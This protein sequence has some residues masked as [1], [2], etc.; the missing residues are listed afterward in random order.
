MV[1]GDDI[2][3]TLLCC[4]YCYSNVVMRDV[5]NDVMYPVAYTS[6]Y[7]PYLQRDEGDVAA[8]N[9]HML[10][11]TRVYVLIIVCSF[12]A[13]HVSRKFN[14]V[15]TFVRQHLQVREL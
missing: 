9:W 6:S 10:V 15:Y 3:E 7:K 5:L 8:I 12:S 14:L 4:R 13:V 11:M 1:N 2:Y